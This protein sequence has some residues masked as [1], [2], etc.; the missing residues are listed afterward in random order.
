MNGLRITLIATLLSSGQVAVATSSP[1]LFD[2]IAPR[3][4][5]V[6]GTQRLYPV[7]IRADAEHDAARNGGIWLTAPDGERSFAR[8]V[9][10]DVQ[11]D[12]NRTWVGQVATS[13]GTR[14]VLITFGRDAIFGSLVSRSGKPFRL[15]TQKGKVYLAQDDKS[16][17]A[18]ALE[19]ISP[20]TM[21]YRLPPAVFADASA[22]A[23]TRSAQL[24]AAASTASP[25]VDVLLGFTPGMVTRQGSA[26]AVVTRLNFLVS[27]ANQAY[28]DSQVNGRV[29][30]V[31]TLEV[32]YPDT[33]DD[34]QVLS[35]LTNT[36][37]S[38]PLAPLRKE[39][40]RVGADL[41]SLIRPFSESGQGGFCGLAYLNGK[42][43]TP[44]TTALSPYGYSTVNDGADPVSG[45]QCA[46]TNLAHQMGHNMGLAHDQPDAPVPGAFSYAYGWRQT[47]ASGSFATIMAY[48]AMGQS[49]VPY[50]A[51]PNIT[52]CN[53]NPCGDPVQADQT[54]VL[55]Q[56]MPV[57][58]AFAAP[59]KASL[60]IDGDGQ[61][62]VLLQNSSVGKV[63]Y[64]VEGA[65]VVP[66][67]N[68]TIAVAAGY[69]IAAVADLNGDH[70]TDLVWTS[71]ANDL[72]FWINDGAGSYN[73]YRGPNVPSG[74]KLIGAGDLNGDGNDDL[75]W[76]NNTTHQFGYWL[77]NGKTVVSLKII[78]VAAGYSIAAIADLTGSGHA[79]LVWTSA[80]HDLYFWINNGAGAFSS[81]RGLDYPAGWQLIG[82]GDIDGD[83]RADLVWTNDSAHQFAYWLMSGSNRVGYKISA[84]MPGYQVVGI[85][86]YAGGTASILWTSAARDLYLWQNDGAGNFSSLQIP[87]YP[88]SASTYNYD[89]PAGWSVI[90]ALPAKP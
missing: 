5:F 39:R 49:Q 24:A 81:V 20:S 3:T 38:G 33:G 67:R 84:S 9:R 47:L 4:S 52:S 70:S 82:S 40:Q 59:G 61:A 34:N 27:V 30:L 69:S 65:N 22:L 32:T 71:A 60:D 15:I 7:H 55:N 12:G 72:Y 35:D 51:D 75:L 73:S 46:D 42:N 1:E 54:L 57:V 6:Q 58:A 62:D 56:T 79:D 13:Q 36:S 76:M 44:L 26:S 14:S 74:W 19:Q 23:K 21:D 85:D 37:S 45:F 2:S 17:A 29:R 68:R 16:A 83:Q 80:A 41:V 53:G 89:Y 11:R 50:F 31:G 87:G 25:T 28:A 77:M 48:P 10:T 78:P 90:S 63:T 18:R 64:M 43:L 88:A 86:R 66:S 8:T